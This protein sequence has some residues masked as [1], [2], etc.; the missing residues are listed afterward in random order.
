MSAQPDDPKNRTSWLERLPLATG[1]P[2]LAVS[3]MLL[4][5]AISFVL[6]VVSDPV[7]PPGFPYVTFFPAVVLSSFLF[8]A[9]IGTAAA[10][11]CGVLAW[12]FFI[13]ERYSFALAPGALIALLFYIFVAGTDIAIIHWMQRAN[14]GLAR[15]REFSRALAET[16]ALLFRELQHRV[17]N[18]LQVA[19]GLISLQKRRVT[20]EAARA[21]LDEASRRL[22]VIGKI[23][24][25]LYDTSGAPRAMD[26]F[27]EPLCRDIVDASGHAGI[28]CDVRIE[29]ATKLNP[30]AAIPVA[31]I[32]TEALA[33][34][35]EHGFAGRDQGRVEVELRR[36]AP[37]RV[38]IEIRDDGH[39]LPDGFD[40]DDSRSLGLRIARMLAGQ[41]SGTFELTGG[42]GTIARLVIPV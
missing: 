12:F 27:L 30:D 5:V 7:L 24:R 4:L 29:A 6:R 3:A 35:I 36:L 23:S 9:R 22:T 34:A 37:D 11:L 8:G 15:E 13:G 31:L 41:L 39:G 32:V 20:D 2:V 42:A 38:C 26:E 18:N 1:R 33:N 28:R 10:V 16:R 19:A 17:S 21:A 25:Q 14:R 40:L